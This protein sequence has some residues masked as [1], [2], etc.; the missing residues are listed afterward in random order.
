MSTH[1]SGLKNSL[2]ALGLGLATAGALLA[3]QSPSFAKAGIRDAEIEKILR[4]YTD[5]IF[6]AAGLDVKAVDVFVINDPSLN[7]FVSGGQNVFLHTGMIMTLDTPNELKGVIAHET[8]H[9]SGGHLARG[10]EAMAKA[11]VP[12]LITMLAGVAAIAAGA[13]DI[14]MALLIGS[15]SVAQ[16]EILAYSRT[17]ESAADQ[18]GVKFMNATGQSPRG[19][20]GVFDRFADQEALSGY[21]QDPFVRSHP[22]SRDRISAMQGLIDESPSKDKLDTP[23]E[24]ADYAMIRAK[25]RGFIEKPQVV[26]RLYPVSDKSAPARYAR[27]AAYFRS[28][29]LPRALPEIDSLIAE[30][31]TYAYYWELK[32]QILVESSNPTDGVPAY[33]KAAELAPNEPLI[34][35]GLGAALLALEDDKLVPEAKK[36]LKQALQDEQDNAMAWY[37]L[38]DAYARTNN[39]DLAAL[40]TAERYFSIGAYGEAMSFARR[41][42][43]K[44][45]EGS[46][47]WQR[48]NDILSIAQA[49]ATEQRKRRR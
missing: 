2:R 40:A 20:L 21:R 48:A 46:N 6:R 22:L 32:G 30:R 18:A 24:L 49:G 12:M 13:P 29:D 1:R 36:H 44:L 39:D 33:R 27:A 28:A 3:S 10:P 25:L 45:K 43:S 15:Q 34:Q 38:A 37:Y 31:P 41:A 26:L 16:R 47:D 11:E 19:M 23:Q 35:V 5:P 42:Q 9:I 17:Q 8:G 7:A 14:G 4:G